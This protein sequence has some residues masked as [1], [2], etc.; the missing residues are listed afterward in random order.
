MPRDSKIS[1]GCHD[2]SVPKSPGTCMWADYGLLKEDSQS[3]S[4]SFCVS[5]A[6]TKLP[7]IPA[8]L[9]SVL[10]SNRQSLLKEE[11]SLR[12]K[13]PFSAAHCRLWKTLPKIQSSQ[14]MQDFKQGK[15]TSWNGT[16]SFA[17]EKGL[18]LLENASFGVAEFACRRKYHFGTKS[19][20]ALQ[21]EQGTC[22]NFMA[23]HTSICLLDLLHCV[24]S[25]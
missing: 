2:Q 8:R 23:G 14:M 16:A 3:S 19:T 9:E 20:I 22:H 1:H 21:G 7:E 10:T 4:A 15:A 24:T 11:S 12:W 13:Y 17:Q 6:A 25:G 5:A 18:H